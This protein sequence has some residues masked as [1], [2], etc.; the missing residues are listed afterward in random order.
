MHKSPLQTAKHLENRVS[1]L[2][3][4]VSLGDTANKAEFNCDIY[5]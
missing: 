4:Y 2:N 1:D 5:H 3:A